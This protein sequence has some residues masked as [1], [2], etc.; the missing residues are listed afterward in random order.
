MEKSLLNIKIRSVFGDIIFE[1]EKENNTIKE[2]LLEAVKQG[3]NLRYADLRHTNL[4]NANLRY[5]DLGG[6]DLRGADLNSA[7]LRYANLSN[8]DL[9]GVDLTY[10][11]LTD[12]KE[13]DTAYMPIYS[14]WTFSM[15]GDKLYIGCKYKTIDEW[16][17]W[18]AG[19]EEYDTR[20]ESPDFKRLHAM[21]L[22]HKAYY[23]FLNK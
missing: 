18:F 9:T 6:A 21:F 4:S 3:A 12:V 5:A 11:D 14:K 22:A 17:E 10:A 19:D 8:T 23:E 2:T 1:Y 13:I 7:N 15:K 20:R 16:E